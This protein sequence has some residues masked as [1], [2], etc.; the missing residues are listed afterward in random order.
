MAYIR[1]DHCKG[2]GSERLTH[3]SEICSSLSR[4][5]SLPLFPNQLQ[6]SRRHHRLDV[7]LVGSTLKAGA[8]FHGQRVMMNVTFH[9]ATRL[10]NDSLRSNCPFHL[11]AH[12]DLRRIDVA[13]NRTVAA[14]NKMRAGDLAL[15]LTV[16][17]NFSLGFQIAS[18]AQ[19]RID[20]RPWGPRVRLGC[21]YADS[22]IMLGDIDAPPNSSPF[23][24]NIAAS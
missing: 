1:S 11:S 15:D 3:R 18:D 20:D 16:D 19:A 22:G 2:G 13:K 6:F 9:L 5:N 23:L 24:L 8:L 12:D 10:K 14:D 7:F 4:A 21:A 17:L